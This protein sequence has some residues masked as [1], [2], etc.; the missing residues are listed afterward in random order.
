MSASTSTTKMS[1]KKAKAAAKSA[2][3]KARVAVSS[4][5]SP[6]K[7]VQVPGDTDRYEAF[8][9]AVRARFA[10]MSA[11]GTPVFYT[12]VDRAAL[13]EAYLDGAPTPE[14]RAHRTCNTCRHFIER[15][16][17]LVVV[18]E[19]GRT[20]SALWGLAT[21][22][23][24]YRD[25]A[26]RMEALVSRARVTG[27][28]LSNDRVLGT[29]ETGPWTH[30]SATQRKA[31]SAPLMNAHQAM[32]LRIEEHGMLLRGLEEFD[33]ETVRKAHAYLTNG[34][35]YR[36]EKCVA[37]AK[38]LL[39]L[40]E[41]LRN[42]LNND[43]KRNALLWRAVATA[44][45]GFCHV[46]TT[47]IGTL[48]TDIASGASFASI[49][50][51]FDSKMNPLQYM[52]P[53]AAPAAGNVRVAEGI[54]EKLE[55][56]GSLSR[57]FARLDDVEA[58]W[59]PPSMRRARHK[60][61]QV[62]STSGE[63]G[64]GIFAGLKTKIKDASAHMPIGNN[65]PAQVMT[66]VKFMTTVL[67]HAEAIEYYVPT[68]NDNYTALVT[69]ANMDAPPILQWDHDDA[70][71]PVSWYVYAGGSTPTSWNLHPGLYCEVSAI[72]LQPTM[73]G[74]SAGN[75]LSCAPKYAHQGMSVNIILK[76]ARDERYTRGAGLFVECLKN[77]YHAIR[78]TLEAH[79]ARSVITGR[80]GAEVCGL[81]LQKD[82]G[83]SD[84]NA[85]VAVTA[86]GVRTTYKLDRWD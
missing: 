28:F 12:D 6:R 41:M 42:T 79:I 4:A 54:I 55:T 23:P 45:I 83:V 14:A 19:D 37:V 70:R 31:F 64:A 67:P 49:K 33:I 82:G 7:V 53:T 86:A 74:V 65:A 15:F 39:D 40:H 57:R 81:R 68:R 50:A 78:S 27:V 36:A 58:L 80:P 61:G 85:T 16:G 18:G 5:N 51:S 48:L 17:G 60:D 76:G 11:N 73:W 30:F 84:W 77:E 1:N 13:W 52:R 22:P 26:V 44:P 43:K 59:L 32:A 8:L 9:A 56:A 2:A 69:A 25:A 62:F 71:N 35:L 10:D 20:H 34:S 66:W 29:P 38:W 75:A 72:V 47:M 3:H 24:A 46:K 21:A 63:V